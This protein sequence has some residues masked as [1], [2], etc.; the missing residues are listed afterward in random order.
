MAADSE[1]VYTMYARGEE[2]AVCFEADSGKILWKNATGP[3]FLDSQGG[4]GPR[5]TPAI[6]GDKVFFIGALGDL[7]AIDR[8][9]GRTVWSRNLVR[10]YWGKAPVWGYAASPV[11]VGSLLLVG[12]GSEDHP[13]LLALDKESGSI[14]WRAKPGKIGYASPT[15]A[16]IHDRDQAIFFTATGL[17]GLDLA[18][19]DELWSFPWE[20]PWQVN[21]ATPVWAPPDRI[22]ITS[23]YDRGAAL[24]RVPK[25]GQKARAVWQS[26]ALG[27]DFSTPILFKNLLFGFDHVTLKC[28][29]PETGNVL[30]QHR[31]LGKGSLIAADGKLIILGENGEL[32]LARAN[33]SA[34]EPLASARVLNGKCWTMP[35]LAA[36][37]LFLRNERAILALDIKAK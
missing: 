29:D 19:G 13:S 15:V 14:V 7:Y 37:R 3:M 33:G 16:R 4:H 20:T 10:D 6:D 8:I 28:I 17:F 35:A 21:A 12:S 2:F 34:F 11:I 22:L 24:I 26:Q 30:W 9:S 23:A 36:G 32:V 31:G 18:K 5:A 27:S 1:R 25:K